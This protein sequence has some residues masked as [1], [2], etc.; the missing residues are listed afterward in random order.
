MMEGCGLYMAGCHDCLNYLIKIIA[1]LGH[2]ENFI[3]VFK[4][5]FSRVCH[6]IYTRKWLLLVVSRAPQCIQVIRECLKLIFN[7]MVPRVAIETD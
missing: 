6:A 7:S 3:T 2:F 1:V 4:F 5:F